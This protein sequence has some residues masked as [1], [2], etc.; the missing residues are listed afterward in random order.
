MQIRAE[1]AG[2][3]RTLVDEGSTQGAGQE[4]P[5]LGY[6]GET[7]V[8]IAGREGISAR[9]V[10]RI[11]AETRTQAVLVDELDAPDVLEIDPFAELARCVAAHR[12]ALALVRTIAHSSRNDAVTGRRLRSARR[13]GRSARAWSRRRSTM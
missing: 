1:M 10:R 12:E 11:L 13:T 6:R 4:D 3:V 8:L 5:G 7:A 9:Q 2:N